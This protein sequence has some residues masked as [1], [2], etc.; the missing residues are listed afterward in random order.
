MNH[1]QAATLA[2]IFEHPIQ[3]SIEWGRIGHMLEALGAELDHTHHGKIKV[4]LNGHT[5]TFTQP[6]HQKELS[7]KS[8]LMALRHFLEEAGVTPASP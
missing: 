2:R 8:E 4:R 1:K 6:H 3:T 7:D 5:A